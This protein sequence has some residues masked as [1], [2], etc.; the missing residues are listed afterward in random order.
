MAKFSKFPVT[1]SHQHLIF[2]LKEE[3]R[4]LGEKL[5]TLQSHLMSEDNH[6]VNKI[7]SKASCLRRKSAFTLPHKEPASFRDTKR[8]SL[9]LPPT[10][11]YSSRDAEQSTGW[12]A[13]PMPEL[14][15]VH[16]TTYPQELDLAASLLHSV[17][18][19]SRKLS[20]QNEQS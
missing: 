13:D 2:F 8:H 6:S 17:C 3:V 14:N 20:P 9:Q 19:H 15:E 1:V 5:A 10:L 7:P 11:K 4:R 16:D 18:V 12:T